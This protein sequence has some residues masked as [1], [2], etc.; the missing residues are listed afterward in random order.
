MG[1]KNNSNSIFT[2]SAIHFIY[3]IGTF[4]VPFAVSWVTFVYLKV[5]SLKNTLI[6]F[7]SP[8]AIM[9]II[10]IYGFILYWY[11]SQ[12]K[13]L[14]QFDPKNPESVIK[15]NKVYKR[16]QSVTLGFALLNAFLSAFLVQGAFAEK[17]FL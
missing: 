17:K 4:L 5:F 8:F 15:T 2:F 11:F 16:F 6:G 10:L 3:Y 13:K 14:K 9:G 12:T 7:T 1:D